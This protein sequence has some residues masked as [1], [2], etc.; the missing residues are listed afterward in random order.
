MG[1]EGQV[2]LASKLSV[3]QDRVT[4]FYGR[5]LVIDRELQ[6]GEDRATEL[7]LTIGARKSVIG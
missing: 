6:T 4:R 5:C 7:D 2:R 1:W 3:D